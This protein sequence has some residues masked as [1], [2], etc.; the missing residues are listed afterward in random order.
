M[1]DAPVQIAYLVSQYPAVSHT[2]ILRE[3][4][5]LRR[6]GF[7]IRVASVRAADRPLEFLTAEEREEQRATFYIKPAG[8]ASA[9]A[10]NLRTLL[11]RPL[12][13]AGALAYAAHLGFE[14]KNLLY[15]AEAVVFADW[16]WR[17]RLSQVHMH[18]STTVGLL[19]R[20][21]APM[22]TSATIHG[23]DEFIDP[24][25]FHLRQKIRVFD[26]VCAISEFGRSQL[27]RFSEPADWDKL[28]VA[29]LGVDPEIY[30][31]RPFRYNPS[32]FE[33]ICV[34]RLAPVK[35]QLVLIAALDRLMRAGRSVRL[36]LVG[37]GEDRTN[38]ENEAAR[39]GLN[40]HVI[41]EGR[42]NAD[43]IRDLYA[44]ADVFA[45][46]SFAEGIPV[47]LMEAMAMEIP[48][49]ATW[50][51]GI[52]ELIRNEVDGL[53]APPS[54]DEALASALARLMDDAELRLRLGKS[55]RRRVLEQYDLN[56]NIA[57][58]ADLLKAVRC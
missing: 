58:F 55:A 49:V 42:Q 5:G 53:L 18:F 37:D 33:I 40:A 16:M 30:A 22:R 51:T 13:Y 27:M 52:P 20:R 3:I 46:A 11:R 48:C 26:L 34:G 4:Q 45:L 28:R 19:A 56:R 12:A 17:Q 41:F 29:R 21:V 23:S 35:G 36:R 1:S 6:L 8:V 24:E 43:R 10:A 57:A 9:L 14:I 44:Q 25:G 15:F 50:I 32:P 31:P 39:R 7:D 54:N 38:L 2:F 47:V